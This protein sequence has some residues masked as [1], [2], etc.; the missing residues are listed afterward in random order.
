MAGRIVLFGATGYTGRLTAEALVARGQRPLL[1]ARDAGRLDALAAE[2]GGGLDTAVADVSRPETVRALVDKG[3]VIVST[4][5]P[6]AK[7][8]DAAADAA[9]A[10]GAHYLDSTGEP[11]F[12][13]RIF[14]QYGP[15]AERAG[16]GM[17][18]AFG[19]DWVPGNLAAALALR[20]AGPE[21]V[22]VDTGYFVTG[23]TGANSFSGGTKASVAG[24]ASEPAFAYRDG[25]LRTV[26][27]AD[28]F[29][30][31]ALRGREMPAVTVGSSEHFALPKTHPGLIEVNSYL[32]WF[33]PLSRPMQAFSLVGGGAMK[34]PGVKALSQ[35]LTDRFV[36][37][38]TG[39]PGPEQR[40]RSGSYVVAE[41]HDA[42]GRKLAEVHVTGIDPYTFTAGILGWGAR[43]AAE[44]GLLASGA[45]GPDG[46]F[47][48]DELEA[49]CREAGLT[50]T[51][52]C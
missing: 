47:G 34:V 27:S 33:G 26:R 43:R 25:A 16:I 1:A 51:D 6:F 8:G 38:S 28:R 49:G 29:R 41:A 37:G 42:A 3:D 21:A 15:Q 39:G 18:T 50:R 52:A 36:K 44:G 40:A 9:I 31:F 24:V 22:R 11:P 32:G 20:D 12:I 45:L 2:L 17:L 7:W 5:G 35:R 4:V 23:A 46:A 19:Y 30:K 48:L 14:E 10:A 13:R